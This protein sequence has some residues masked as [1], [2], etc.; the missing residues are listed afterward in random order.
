M[1]LFESAIRLVSKASFGRCVFGGKS[2]SETGKSLE[3]AGIS[4]ASAQ[5]Y[6]SGSFFISVGWFMLSLPIFLAFFGDAA[7]SLP[8]AMV[9]S[10]LLFLLLL[11][12]PR[13]AAQKRTLRC[14]AELPFIL[15]ELSVYIDV[16]IPFEKAMG[17]IALGSYSLSREFSFACQEMR[18]GATMQSALSSAFSQTRSVQVKRCAML[19]STVYE[20]GSRTESLKRTAEE[21]SSSQLSEMRLLSG[22]LSLLS[23][24]F[25]ASS[26]L[27]P[28]FFSVYA[29]VAP[30]LSQSA[31]TGF[32]VWAAFL[33]LFPALNLCILAATWHL[34]PPSL[35][36]RQG[37]QA[38]ADDYLAR[39]G[40]RIGATRLFT[41]AFLLSAPLALSAL[42]F[43][44]PI[45]CAFFLCAAPAA[46]F[47]LQFLSGAEVSR[48]ESFL[49]DALYGAASLHR[50]VPFEKMMSNLA[51][52]DF[53][54]LSVAFSLAVRRI[55]AG[56]GFSSAMASAA[57]ECP[58][59]LSERAFS[60]LTVCYETGANMSSAFRETAQDIASFFALV[61]E[62]SAV[63]SIQRY[64]II[65]ASALLVPFILGSTLSLVPA[66]SSASLLFGEGEE[67]AAQPSGI[68][69]ASLPLACQA[70]LL[71]NAFLSSLLLGVS[72][73]KAWKA[74]PYFILTAPLS[75]IFFHI[76]HSGAI[77]P[78]AA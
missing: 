65:L 68:A 36:S 78:A 3:S 41:L 73:G 21:L 8:F 77:L 19:L 10:A 55:R 40:I 46:Y 16:G 44:Q 61:R 26:A 33:L 31:L 20:T 53:G 37:G 23:I 6:L 52:G 1:D 56:D 14:E 9:F 59:P 38:A 17:R 12:L 66:L 15:R 18:S 42:L 32:Q 67:G 54:R 76:A 51:S 35:G 4:G 29:A 24:A 74:A 39:R 7:D 25:I 45:L 43:G 60:M 57:R 71:V 2:A 13:L 49:P 69:I 30:L 62:R 63:L 50:L 5:Q 48:A 34:L 58:S 72:E 11:S 75:E 64:T 70:Y 28:S 47:L 27:V 22:R